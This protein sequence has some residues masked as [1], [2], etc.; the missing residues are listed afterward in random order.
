V[1]H[2]PAHLSPIHCPYVPIHTPSPHFLQLTVTLQSVTIQIVF[3][4]FWQC[5][6]YI[7]I[8]SLQIIVVQV[9][10]FQCTDVFKRFNWQC[11]DIVETCKV[12]TENVIWW[13]YGQLV[14]R[15][16]YCCL[17]TRFGF[18][19]TLTNVSGWRLCGFVSSQ[20]FIYFKFSNQL[21][22]SLC[23]RSLFLTL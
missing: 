6:E 10:P 14:Y 4:Q 1:C 13:S 11:T 9:K 22:T 2:I 15:D 12:V 23:P 18:L 17:N 20:T 7:Y 8:Y 16:H 21:N 19:V 3:G 5:S